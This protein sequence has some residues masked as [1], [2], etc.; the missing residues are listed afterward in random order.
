V[1]VNA[2]APL[3][4]DILGWD[5][6]TTCFRTLLGS[7]GTLSVAR[8]DT[9]EHRHAS[10]CGSGRTESGDVDDREDEKST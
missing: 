6:A 8:S 4:N 10:V 3:G 9:L 1:K 5:R 7:G 2:A